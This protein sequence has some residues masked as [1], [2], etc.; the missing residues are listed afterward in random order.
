MSEEQATYK[1]GKAIRFSAQVFKFQTLIDGG[2]R[3]TLDLICPLD[4][5][6]LQLLA[7]RQ[8]GIVLECAA[9][10]IMPEKQESNRENGEVPARSKWKP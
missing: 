8:P 6:I 5:T 7:A 2:T 1:A 10:A 9:V 4:D 3:L